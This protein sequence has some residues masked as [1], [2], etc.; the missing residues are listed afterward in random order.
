M[1]KVL[2]M[3][4]QRK[5][6]QTE[7]D[8][9]R[10]KTLDFD[11]RK[12]NLEIAIG[13]AETEE[14]QTGVAALVT[15]YEQERSTHDG[16]IARLEGEIAD[17]TRQ[18]QEA[19]AKQ[20]KPPA[21]PPAADPAPTST[22][23]DEREDDNVMPNTRGRIL[24]LTRT[25]FGELVQRD[26]NKQCIASIRE[27][28]K[29]SRSISGGDLLMSESFMGLIREN[30]P[31]FS[32]LYKHVFVRHLRGT[33]RMTVMGTIPEGIWTEMCATLNQ[34]ILSFSSVE[35]DGYMVGGYIP[36]CNA[37]LEDSDIALAQEVLTAITKAIALALDKAIVY[38]TGTKMPM[39]IITR[40]TQTVQP[41]NYKNSMPWKNLSESHVLALGNKT[42]MELFQKL[43]E[44]SGKINTDFGPGDIFWAMN[45]KTKMKL[46]SESLGVNANGTIVAG[47]NN[48]MPVVGGEIETLAFFPDDVIL[49]GGEGLY[50]LLERAGIHLN[51]YNQ[52]LAIQNQTLFIGTSRYDGIPVIADGFIAISLGAAKPT[53]SAV[54]FAADKANAA[55]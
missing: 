14:E 18:I 47:M 38:G 37:L 28:G 55:A 25:Q 53:A 19:E 6:L 4:Q 33:G 5:R 40:L 17:L 23:T 43:L 29:N 7:L 49:A 26:E 51:T 22:Y 11:Q 31:L 45:R 54:T 8:N 21:A 15:E 12:T 13:Q 1:L 32:K 27:M 46:M 42:G 24:G 50:A 20:P 35:M 9:L 3:N 39:G 44:A 30:V 36:V 16:E 34:L 52:T 2:L 41:E 10:A 48:T